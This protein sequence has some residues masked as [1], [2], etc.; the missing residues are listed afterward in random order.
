MET[1]LPCGRLRVIIKIHKQDKNTFMNRKA[2]LYT[3]LPALVFIAVGGLFYLFLP[4]TSAPQRF[5]A[6]VSAAAML[7]YCYAAL[8]FRRGFQYF[9]EKLRKAYVQ[10]SLGIAFLGVAEAQLPV[11]NLVSGLSFWIDSGAML[12][13]F[14]VAVVL[15]LQGVRKFA[16]ETGVNDR[17]LSLPLVA[18]ISLVA[19]V[20]ASFIPHVPSTIPE[21]THGAGMALTLAIAIFFAAA[22][23]G[24]LRIRKATGASYSKSLNWL[25][26]AIYGAIAASASYLGELLFA[27]GVGWYYDWSITIALFVLDGWLF[28]RA[29]Y[30]FSVIGE[31]EETRDASKTASSIDIILYVIS[32]ASNARAV[33][34]LADGLRRVT[35]TLT[36]DKQLS[37]EGQ[38][39]LLTTYRSLE[40]YLVTQEP[41]R[42]L[43]R[44]EVRRS[45]ERSLGVSAASTA[46]FWPQVAAAQPAP[47]PAPAPVPQPAPVAPTEENPP[48]REG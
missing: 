31:P 20:A 30:A 48:P 38:A 5:S 8:L 27:G 14:I 7:M 45:V 1:F 41:L 21:L 3:G 25:A 29:G 12:L 44:E 10:L 36:G 32:L 39:Q 13:P 11:I 22:L 24:V 19:G 15:M 40:D 42:K 28:V 26:A 9:T 17:W 43:N 16:A 23:R 2:F 33:D 18:G 35:S 6:G 4:I 37:A 47:A 34:P 46:T